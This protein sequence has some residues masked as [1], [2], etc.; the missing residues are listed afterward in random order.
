MK[1]IELESLLAGHKKDS[2]LEQY[3]YICSLI[4]SGRIKPVQ[5]SALNGKKPALHKSYWILENKEDNSG[6]LDEIRFGLVPAIKI[7]YYLKHP[8]V[9]IQERKWVLQ[10]NDFLRRKSRDA[11][12]PVSLN[13]RSFEIWGREKFLQKEQGKKILKHCGMEPDCLE[14]YQTTE[15]LSYYSHSR[16]T[17]QTI[18][19]LENKD[20]FY[21]MRRHLLE[22]GSRIFGQEIGTLIYGAGKGIL[23]SF[24]DFRF[25]VEPYMNAK[26]NR[27]LYFGDLDYE[28]IA[29]FERLA[30]SFSKEA[31]IIPFA[32]AYEY[33]L[34]KYGPD[35]MDFLPETSENQN[36]SISGFFFSF[37]SESE[38]GQMKRIIE[39]GRYIPQ[40]S[41]NIHDF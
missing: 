23:R 7:D 16:K 11:V 21:S 36:R 30:E 8:D 28:G 35:K 6:Y 38:A 12:L 4:Q 19:I 17:P 24:E 14:I 25:C 33:M 40:E 26:E 41:L 2:Y 15:P 37:F 39:Q 29:I 20:T 13:E 9:Y 27:L 1:R 5:K 31:E 22:G 18:L 34:E 32:E 3:K 10:L